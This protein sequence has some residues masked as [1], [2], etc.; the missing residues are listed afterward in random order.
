MGTAVGASV[1]AAWLLC[2]MG[3]LGFRVYG[4]GFRVGMFPLI[5]TVR[6]RDYSTPPLIIILIG[7]G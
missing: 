2:N 6:T 4:L 1:G 7:D 5:L 3:G